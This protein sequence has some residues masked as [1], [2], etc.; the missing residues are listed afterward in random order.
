MRSDNLVYKEIFVELLSCVRGQVINLRGNH[1][2]NWEE[3]NRQDREKEPFKGKSVKNERE[4]VNH[5][6]IEKE[7]NFQGVCVKV[8]IWSE[9]HN[10]VVRRFVKGLEDP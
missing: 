6:S 3:V 2:A 4:Q 8:L 10:S 9:C 5:K 1:E 7:P